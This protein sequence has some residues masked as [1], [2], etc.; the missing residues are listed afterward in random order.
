MYL[1]LIGWLY[2][3]LMM[4][5]AEA[6]S[7]AGTLLGALVTVVCYGVLP[8]ALVAYLMGAPARRQAIRRREAAEMATRQMNGG[9][10][11]TR[12]AQA[13]DIDTRQAQAGD[14]HHQQAQAAATQTG[15]SVTPDE[16]PVAATGPEA[17]AVAP[18]REKP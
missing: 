16:S 9:D 2:V 5:V 3:A 15:D 12:Q 10:I 11:D 17:N 4:G 8:A 18:V 6:T 13:G 14:I 7:P 1:V